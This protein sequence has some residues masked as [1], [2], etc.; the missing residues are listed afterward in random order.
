[1]TSYC[2]VKAIY[3]KFSVYA[4]PKPSTL[5]ILPSIMRIA[6][7][8]AGVLASL[9]P[10]CFASDQPSKPVF[11]EAD[12]Y[13][14]IRRD[15]VSWSSPESVVAGLR[16]PDEAIRLKSLQLLGFTDEMAH[17]IQWS[18]TNPATP[19][20]KRV[21]TPDEIRLSYASL[22]E[23]SVKQAILSVL[24]GQTTFAAVAMPASESWRRIA[25]FDCWCKYDIKQNDDPLSTFLRLVPVPVNPPASQYELVFRA[26]G[27]GTGLYVQ[28]EA[29]YRVYHGELR[30]VFS[31]ESRRRQC[32]ITNQ[33]LIERGWFYPNMVVNRYG[34]PV[35]G[36]VLAQG[37]GRLLAEKA[38]Q[39]DWT[40]R[41]IEPR[42]LHRLVCT[43]FLWNEDQLRYT[44]LASVPCDLP[45]DTVTSNK[46]TSNK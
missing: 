41:E 16:S 13:L 23:G 35:Q 37:K 3:I 32:D 20:G 7:L 14:S 11:S 26:S 22:G 9:A 17:E 43:T 39:V 36:G 30:K 27:G 40:V 18:Q 44:K 31:L 12:G 2:S 10:S 45:L 42:H 38:P 21:I 5:Y 4:I 1:M 46:A 29:H 24:A 8:L 33:C 25:A 19:L 34:N 6:V 15:P 28:N